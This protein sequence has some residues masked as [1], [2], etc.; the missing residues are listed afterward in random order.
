[1]IHFFM[2]NCSIFQSF[3]FLCLYANF[4][5]LYS[6]VKK[7]FFFCFVYP[8]KRTTPN[9]ACLLLLLILLQRHVDYQYKNAISSSSH[10]ST[11]SNCQMW[12]L[13][14]WF[15]FLLE[16]LKHNIPYFTL[17]VFRT[18]VHSVSCHFFLSKI[19]QLKFFREITTFSSRVL[20][21]D[22]NFFQH[23]LD[24]WFFMTLNPIFS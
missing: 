8:L 23:G 2:S 13:R 12:S 9:Y 16:I 5:S 11:S 20:S 19:V 7:L 14:K 1:M 6:N 4:F 24:Y 22:T 3:L 10:D 15:L 21:F 18:F 17:S